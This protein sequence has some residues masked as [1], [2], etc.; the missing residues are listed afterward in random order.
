MFTKRSLVGL[1]LGSE[2]IKA[3][4]MIDSDGRM[5]LNALATM[6]AV[7]PEDLPQALRQLFSGAGIKT[8][9][10][11]ISL[12]GKSVVV[13]YISMPRMSEDELRSSLKYEAEKHIPFDLDEVALD[14]AILDTDGAP[15]DGKEVSEMQVLLVAARKEA[16]DDLL[17]IV[18]AAGLLPVAVD[19][20]GFALGSAF[21]LTS[22]PSSAEG[23]LAGVTALVDVGGSKTSINILDDG[24]SFFSREIYLAGKDFTES[25][26]RRMG[27]SA[28]EG[29]RLKRES[30][31]DNFEVLECVSPLLGDL[32]AEIHASM[33][34]FENHHERSVDCVRLSGGS[35]ALPGLGDTFEQAFGREVREW[36][37]LEGVDETENSAAGLDSRANSSQLAVAVGLASRVLDY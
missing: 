9:N 37:P 34:Y 20:D 16:L 15:E 19:V 17:G 10:V 32:A 11:A 13:R 4:E 33:D 6:P 1:D 22:S 14:C 36:N 35:A 2:E 29:D 18:R 3:V 28:E 23:G 27:V 31:A 30:S 26:S 21:E 24:V 7:D 5:C 8:R 12:S 25:I